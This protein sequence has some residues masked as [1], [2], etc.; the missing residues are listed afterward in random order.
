MAERYLK[1]IPSGVVYIFQPAFAQRADFIEVADLAGTPLADAPA[2]A[3]TDVPAADKKGR[4]KRKGDETDNLTDIDAALSATA[5]RG[6][7][8]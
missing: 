4:S 3:P 6:L 5:S 2:D 8:K 7:A 1:H